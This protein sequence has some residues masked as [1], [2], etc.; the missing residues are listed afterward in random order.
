MIE[1]SISSFLSRP[2]ARAIWKSEKPSRLCAEHQLGR[3]L[4]KIA[5]RYQ[6]AVGVVDLLQFM[7][8]PAVYAC[9]LVDAIDGITLVEG[10]PDHEDTL[11]G[12]SPQSLVD[13]GHLQF[14]VVGKTVHALADHAE[15]FL[16]SLFECAA[17]CH[18]LADRLHRRLELAVHAR[19]TCRGPSAGFCTPHSRG[20][21][22]RMPWCPW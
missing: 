10:L 11:V 8:E 17:D 20:P 19:G 3:Y 4:G 15:A 22:Q 2:R 13:I 21:A 16:D 5:Q 14:L 12:G 9:Q 1:G 6:L 18:D 7:Q